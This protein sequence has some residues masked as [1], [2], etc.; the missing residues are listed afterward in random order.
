[1]SNLFVS[2]SSQDDGFVQALQRALDDCGH[3]TW[4]DSRKLYGGDPLWSKIRQAI[5]EAAAFAVVVSPK[6]LQSKWTGKELRHALDVQ[7]ARGKDKYPVLPLSLDDTKLGV[8]EEYFD[9]EPLYIP[10]SSGAGGVEAALDA[11]LVAMGKRLPAERWAAAQPQPEPLEELV[12]HLTYM[13]IF[14]RDGVRRA[15]ARASLAY[16]PATPGR[17][18]V[19]SAEPWRLVAPIGPIE[20]D[21]LRWY[22]EKYAIWPSDYFRERVDKIEANLVEWGMLLYQAALPAGPSADVLKAWARISDHA[23]RRFSVYVDARIE[24]GAAVAEAARE[25]ATLLLGLPW[26]LIHDGKSF[27]FQGA[28]PV[29]VRRR[30]P[31]TAP[32]DVPVVAPPIRVLLVTARPEDEACGY[33]DHRAS[34]LPLVQA[35]EALGG[36]VALRILDPPTLPALGKELERAHRAGQPYHVVHFDGHGVYDRKVGLVGLCFEHPQDIGKLTQRRHQTVLTDELGGLLRDHRIPLVFLEA[37]QTAQAEKASESVASEML[38]QGVVSVVAMSHSVLVVTASRFVE[39]FY[40]ALAEGRR[41]GAAMLAGQRS[42]KDDSFRGQVFGKGAFRLQDWFV[43][44]LF[45]EKHDPQLFS[46]LPSPQTREDVAAMRKRRMG[47]LPAEPKTGFVGR[48]RELLALQRLLGR[49]PYAVIRGQGGEGKT[50]LAAEFAR[51]SIHSQQINRAAFV[52]VEQSS[53]AKAVLDAIGRQLV[54]QYSVAEFDDLEKAVLPVERALREQRILLVVDN[55]ERVLLPP[56]VAAETPEAL[57][58]ESRRALVEILA[59]CARLNAVGE[60]RLVFTSRE[61]LP[62]PFDK[63]HNRLELERLTR[64]DAVKLVEAV[65]GQ[66]SGGAGASSDAADEAIAELVD[67][68]HGHARTLA[69]LAPSLRGLGVAAT[70]KSLV[71]LMAEMERRFPGSREKSVL[72]SVELSLRRLSPEN[73]KRARVLGVFHGAVDLG[74]LHTMTEWE[75][76]DVLALARELVATGLATPDPYNHLGLNPALCPY[77]RLRMDPMESAPLAVRW[78][79]AMRGY[80]GFLHQLQ[81]REVAVA[82]KRTLLDLP[83]LFVMLER[84]QRAGDPENTIDLTSSL[85]S[86]L[87]FLGKPRLLERVAQTR[88]RA[89]KA[90]GEIW[91]HAHFEARRTGVVQ[92]HNSGQLR[93]AFEGAQSLLRCAEAAGEDAYSGAD[94]DL[95]MAFHLLG[96]VTLGAGTAEQALVLLDKARSRFKAIEFRQPDRGAKAMA[97]VCF[98]E[99]ANCLHQLGHLDEAAQAFAE[100][101]RFD[102]ENGNERDVAVGKYNLGAVRLSQHRCKEALDLYEEARGSF[103][104][105]KEPGSVAGI[106]HQIGRAHQELEQLE[107]AEDAYRQSLMIGVQAGDVAGQARTLVHLGILYDDAWGRTEEAVAFLRQAAD[108]FAEIPDL[109]DEGRARNNLAIRLRKL[110]RFDEARQEIRRAV[111][112]KARFGHAAEPW[113]VWNNLTNIETEAGN[114]TAATQAKQK[115]L[116]CYLAYRRDGGENHSADGRIALAVTEQL[117]AGG[118]V[119]ASSFLPQVAANSANAPLLPFIHALQAILAG[120]R[121]RNL[122]NAPDLHYSMAAEI[123]LLIETLE[124]PVAG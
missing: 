9:E 109:A 123:I 50:A 91:N 66:G 80:V 32:R 57:S 117:R 16:E 107:D 106:W 124:K 56:F 92:E 26:E 70:R 45:Q 111:V 95:A 76:S 37:C 54:A 14:E 89:A 69:L 99:R 19:E 98:K 27:L 29:R 33:I 22:L 65:L 104:S 30:L 43:P 121:D 53:D 28:K 7:K 78:T 116:E 1:M 24:A 71:E 101:I 88:D 40:Q 114:L 35:M 3:V 2:H 25:A 13:G 23:E 20:A 83:N 85:H 97:S 75:E 63:S 49:E 119:A 8:L 87:Q 115:A 96:Q 15:S 41:V 38:K 55:M 108:K 103:A 5:E 46:R 60:T 122:A 77:L 112:C 42:L 81:R 58:E 64:E 120:S 61:V 34:A 74:V 67:E 4:T 12:L 31:N 62:E 110:G 39:A 11:I 79:E 94:Y 44:M 100:A 36:L 93:K 118:P 102:K 6:S 47:D 82:A 10:V 84:V 72:A 52:S 18:T 86:L 17:P 105:M 59:L 68:V 21:E 51:W 113:K 90:L 73:Q 48:S